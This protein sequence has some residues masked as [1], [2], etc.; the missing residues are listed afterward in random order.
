M[1]RG[2]TI[3][4]CG[5]YYFQTRIS[6]GEMNV[7][8]INAPFQRFGT[9]ATVIRS[10]PGSSAPL[11]ED[12]DFPINQSTQ[13]IIK[14]PGPWTPRVRVISISA[15]REGPEIIARFELVLTN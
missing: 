3:V 1:V 2:F 14:R 13:I 7:G 6:E 15:V 4:S 8:A 5:P 11:S 12:R 9:F 10:L